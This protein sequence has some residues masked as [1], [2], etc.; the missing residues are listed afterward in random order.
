[1]GPLGQIIKVGLSA[2]A[3]KKK[4][5]R[6]DAILELSGDSGLG[7]PP[8]TA[9]VITEPVAPKKKKGPGPGAGAKKK[10]KMADPLPPVVAA[11]AWARVSQWALVSVLLHFSLSLAF[12]DTLVTLCIYIIHII[13]GMFGQIRVQ[14]MRN[15]LAGTTSDTNLIRHVTEMPVEAAQLKLLLIS[16]EPMNLSDNIC[17]LYLPTWTDDP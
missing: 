6:K 7:P 17:Q 13:N 5:K 11:S 16:S 3:P 8:V 2:S 10:A 4:T 9:P 14:E 15:G 12:T 1:M